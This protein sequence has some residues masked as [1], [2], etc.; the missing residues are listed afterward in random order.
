MVVPSFRNRIISIQER[1]NSA[2]CKT[3]T[4]LSNPGSLSESSVL[5]AK[6]AV[7]VWCAVAKA[8]GFCPVLVPFC[9][10]DDDMWKV[11]LD[12]SFGRRVRR[13]SR[14]FNLKGVKVKTR[15]K[16]KICL[17]SLEKR[18]CRL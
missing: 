16:A 6:S 2:V 8:M 14:L 4:N 18:L 17:T 13:M 3:R 7:T 15:L 5:L 1:R 10:N 12:L 11:L 9:R